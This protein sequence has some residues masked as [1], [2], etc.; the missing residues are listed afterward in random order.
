MAETKK[1]P[2][3][4]LSLAPDGFYRNRRLCKTCDKAKSAS[5]YRENRETKLAKQI[6]YQ[7][8]RAKR[9]L[10]RLCS[11]P[12][13]NPKSPY[14]REHANEAL[15]RRVQRRSRSGMT[16]LQLAEAKERERKR[17]RYR[18]W[19]GIRY[20]NHHRKMRA[21]WKPMVAAGGVRCADCGL[22]I[23]PGEPWDLGHAPGGG[24]TDYRGPE[25]ARCNRATATKR[26]RVDREQRPR[27]LP[28]TSRVW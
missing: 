23:H 20:G 7:R 8:A 12:S 27:Q 6:E 16:P 13:W 1:C 28:L 2:N 19:H 26:E 4:G 3:C 10:C 25:H 24:P 9:R 18:P 11:K 5:Y 15:E 21:S 14:C 22:F 17:R